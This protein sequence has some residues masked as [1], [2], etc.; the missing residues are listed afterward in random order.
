MSL[1]DDITEKVGAGSKLVANKAK[2][3]S[4]LANI[5]AQIVSC[6]NTLVKNYKELG[7]AYYEAHKD[8][9]DKEF[10]DI[11]K[12]IK[13]AS[14]KK[15]DLNDQLTVRKEAMKA[16]GVD[17]SDVDDVAEKAEE[18]VDTVKEAVE[19]ITE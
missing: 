19:D 2:E 14:D 17:T 4:E 7:K 15:T 9:I 12:N 3:V 8:D 11:M 13:D 5:R 16:S 1:W 18:A 6:D 10:A